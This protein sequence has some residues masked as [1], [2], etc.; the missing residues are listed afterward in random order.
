MYDDEKKKRR[1]RRGRVYD[2]S[3]N[4]TSILVMYRDSLVIRTRKEYEKNNS[5]FLFLNSSLCIDDG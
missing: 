1:R 4:K 2:G 5:L 3:M